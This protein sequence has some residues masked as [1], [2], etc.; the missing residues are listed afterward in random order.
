MSKELYDFI[1]KNYNPKIQYKHNNENYIDI[2]D[3]FIFG[4]DINTKFIIDNNIQLVLRIAKNKLI[5]DIIICSMYN[6]KLIELLNQINLYFPK[7]KILIKFETNIFIIEYISIDTLFIDDNYKK[8]FTF[9]ALIDHNSKYFYL[10]TRILYLFIDYNNIKDHL[11]KIKLDLVEILILDKDLLEKSYYNY[12]D[13][14]KCFINLKFL[15]IRNLETYIIGE[16]IYTNEQ[17]E[18]FKEYN[19]QSLLNQRLIK[20]ANKI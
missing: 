16:N 9:T 19:F 3:K 6:E 17:I 4:S 5:F 14:I 13:I 20:N 11:D 18:E 8:Y 1:V 2:D 7:Y 15:I 10:E 12:N